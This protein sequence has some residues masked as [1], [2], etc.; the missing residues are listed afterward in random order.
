MQNYGQHKYRETEVSTADRGRLVVLLY[1][2]AINFLKNAKQ[3][4]QEGNTEG[5]CNNINR[6]QDII[7]KLEF[8]L[9]MKE[10]GEIAENLRSLYRFMHTYLVRP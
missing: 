9:N 2:G 8:S 3:S 1:D 6:A 10:G 5:K 7:Q 4:I